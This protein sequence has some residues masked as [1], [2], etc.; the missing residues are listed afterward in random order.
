MTIAT[1]KDLYIDQLQDI[2]SAN[3]QS[4]EATKKMHEKATS[5]ALK[6]ALKAGV[7]GIGE[8]IEQVG[9]IIKSHDAEP[10]G[11]FC[12]GME[13]LVKEV[14]AH[15]LEA[16]I[17]DKDVLDASIITQYQRMTHYGLAGYGTVVAFAKRLGLNDDAK[18]LQTCLDNTYSGDRT[19][20]DIATGEVNKAAMSN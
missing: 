7:D 11:E 2:Y 10:T 14:K 1:L 4:L 13:G 19:M 6:E 5:D 3:K 8:G 18:T 12:K 15:A 17:E 16:D 9:K 20:T